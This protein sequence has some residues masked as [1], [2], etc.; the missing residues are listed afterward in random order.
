M[1]EK[2][3]ERAVQKVVK[4]ATAQVGYV[5]KATNSNL[6]EMT[7]NAGS[8][9]YTK[10]AKY[11]D[12]LRKQGYNFYNGNKNG[13][14]WCDMFF[15]WLQCHLWGHDIARNM[16]YQP[17]DSCGAGCPYSAGYYRA[18]GAW[19]AR[20][21]T[22]KA[23]DQIFFGA[24]TKETH[25]GL[26]VKVDNSKVYTIEGNSSNRVVEKS[27]YR[28]DGNISGYG[29][30]NYALVAEM[31]EDEDE[32]SVVKKFCNVDVESLSNGCSG[33]CVKALQTMLNYRNKAGLGVDGK[34]GMITDGEV[35]KYQQTR[36]LGVD[37]VVGAIT[38]GKLLNEG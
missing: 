26:V 36:G 2:A 14:D 11:F 5:E 31:F 29:R 8:N 19:I 25:T 30:P 23:G 18:H 37:G 27:Y 38:W 20:N 16:L 13:F 7:A 33:E 4:L 15:D 22:P 21:G 10:Y 6:D 28:A 17:M 32:P 24:V 35:R 1:S 12:D 9:N 3:I 34:F